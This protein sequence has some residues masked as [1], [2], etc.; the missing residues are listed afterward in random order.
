MSFSEKI[1]CT[2]QQAAFA[3][4]LGKSTIYELMHDG[5]IETTKVYGRRLIIVQSLLTLLGNRAEL[6]SARQMLDRVQP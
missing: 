4:G 5:K 3:S 1:T 6:P 2:V